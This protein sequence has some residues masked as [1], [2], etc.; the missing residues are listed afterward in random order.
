MSLVVRCWSGGRSFERNDW[1]EESVVHYGQ[2][3]RFPKMCE[4]IPLFHFPRLTLLD[5]ADC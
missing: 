2:V 4:V 3:L 1:L 5:R